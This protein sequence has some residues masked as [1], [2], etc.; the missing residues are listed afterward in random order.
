MGS[1]AAR[2]SF[3]LARG[4]FDVVEALRE[5]ASLSKA[6]CCFFQGARDCSP[7]W[8]SHGNTPDLRSW[9]SPVAQVDVTG[10]DW[11]NCGARGGVLDRSAQQPVAEGFALIG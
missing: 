4:I 1:Y 11:G 2:K 10:A 5:A 3:F 8:E 9:Q 7:W 6:L